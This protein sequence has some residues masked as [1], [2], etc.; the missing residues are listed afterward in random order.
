MGF[1]TVFYLTGIGTGND[2]ALHVARICRDLDAHLMVLV[3][4]LSVPP[5]T[6]PY[7]VIGNEHWAEE[8]S[9]GQQ[10]VKARAD[11]LK[12]ELS[13]KVPGL[14][15]E[16]QFVDRATLPTLAARFARYAD[17]TLI[18][19]ARDE[20]SVFHGCTV[21]G[22][23]FE[24]GRPVLL[25]PEDDTVFPNIKKVMVAWDASVEASKAV[26]DGIGIMKRA[27][28]TDIVLI[29]PVPSFDGHGPEPGSDLARYLNRHGISATVHCIPR[30]G[31]ET[32]DAL[33]ATA[34]DLG[35][36]LIIMGGFGH[37]RL[38]QRIFGGTT[39]NMLKNADLPIFM[40]H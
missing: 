5:P 27:E 30:Q 31:R 11:E 40:A 28:A 25:L 6:S 7:G 37:S 9:Q 38:R 16:A 26:R 1:K 21:D 4:G 32:G 39:T 29:D 36:E 34:R 3:A 8:I 14:V 35:S 22:A 24:S 20:T 2:D 17:L 18:P 33:L 12:A 23:L 10:E 19:P 15:V 13:E